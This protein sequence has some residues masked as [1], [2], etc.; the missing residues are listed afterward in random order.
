MQETSIK[1]IFHFGWFQAK[2]NEKF[3]KTSFEAHLRSLI[4]ETRIFQ[5]NLIQLLFSPYDPLPT[6]KNQKKNKQPF[7]KEL[8]T[9]GWQSNKGENVG[10]PTEYDLK[11][12]SVSFN[13]SLE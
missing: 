6:C 5:N 10:F 7:L 1:K 8:V 2:T 4:V 11:N 12:S 3:L 13:N 9:G